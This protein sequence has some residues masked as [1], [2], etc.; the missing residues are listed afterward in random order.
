MAPECGA[1]AI[2]RRKQTGANRFAPLRV[3]HASCALA[4]RRSRC[5]LEQLRRQLL[6]AQAL[7]VAL[8]RRGELALALGGGFFVELAGAKLGEQAG[9]FDGALEAAQGHLEGLVFANA[10]ARH[11][12]FVLGAFG[13][14]TMCGKGAARP[15]APSRGNPES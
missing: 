5:V 1:G 9:L 12:G 13:G 14:L 4:A 7:V 10:K 2:R 3:L 8:D 6:A 11:V 15:F